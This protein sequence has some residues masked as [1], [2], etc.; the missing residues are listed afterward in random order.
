[1]IQLIVKSDK[2]DSVRLAVMSHMCLQQWEEAVMTYDN[3]F[4]SINEIQQKL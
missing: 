4:L 2:L 1:M 3:L